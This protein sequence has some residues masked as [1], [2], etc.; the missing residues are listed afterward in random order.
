MLPLSVTV[1]HASCLLR[2]VDEPG[3]QRIPVESVAEGT[4]SSK[5]YLAK[6][7]PRLARLGPVDSQRGHHGGVVLARLVVRSP[8][9]R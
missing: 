5:A 3:G 8:W 2:C 9:N 7:G 1:G 4:G 6:I